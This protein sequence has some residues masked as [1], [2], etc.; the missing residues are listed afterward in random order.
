VLVL[1]N[2]A[3]HLVVLNLVADG[4]EVH[5]A[6]RK[7]LSEKVGYQSDCDQDVDNRHD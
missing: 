6:G 1:V 5:G 2:E 3:F 4:I 7:M